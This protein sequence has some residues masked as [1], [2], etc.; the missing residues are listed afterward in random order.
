MIY[1]TNGNSMLGKITEITKDSVK[2]KN[3]ANPS[4]QIFTYGAA[5]ILFAFNA[6]GN[7]LV[8]NLT[9]S[10]V[11]KEKHE[12]SEANARLRPFDIVV[13]LNGKLSSINITSETESKI[14][15]GN[16]N[17]N[18]DSLAFV[19]RKNSNHELF[20]DA[21][22]ALPH[23]IKNKAKI[24]SLLGYARLSAGILSM[25]DNSY[26]NY[27]APDMRVFGR[28]VMAKVQEFSNI[29][30]AIN[31]GKIN[32]EDINRLIDS[33]RSNLFFNH[34][35]LS[36]IEASSIKTGE[37]SI[38]KLRDYLNNIIIKAGH[39]DKVIVDYV[40]VSYTTKFRKG[41]D[42]NYYGTVTFIQKIHGFN[43]GNPVFSGKTQ[44]NLTFVLPPSSGPYIDSESGWDVYLDD[45]GIEEKEKL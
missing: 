30:I 1:L 10:F 24:D 34:G 35:K 39:F 45:I 44:Q 18:K 36:R 3:L 4:E 9:K 26:N 21:D 5:N 28:K 13:D 11:D 43:D 6:A 33:R 7:Y 31:L 2:F 37:K 8:F 22:H 14:S 38:Y 42:G 32:N 15:D 17:L 23:L 25:P 16:V 41:P 27:V 20:C 12:F 40:N 19:I 29:L